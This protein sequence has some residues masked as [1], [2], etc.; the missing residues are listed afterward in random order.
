[1]IG[2]TKLC[3]EGIEI[4][5]FDLDD[6]ILTDGVNVSPRVLDAITLARERGCMACVSSGRSPHMVPQILR[7][8]QAMDYLVC[9]NGS[10]VCDNIGGTMRELLIP[11]EHALAA[12]D[13]LEPLG[14][15]WNAFIGDQSYFEWRSVSYMMVGRGSTMDAGQVRK[16]LHTGRL[17]RNVHRGLRFTKRLFTKREGFSQVRRVRPFLEASDLDVTKLGCSL[18]SL[19]ACDRAIAILEHMGGFE[20]ARMRATE[21][22]ITAAGATKGKAAGWLM[23]HL[24]IDPARAVAFG[25]SEND[26]TLASA[27]GTFVVMDNGDKAVKQLADDVCESVYDDGVARWIERALA[28]AD[29]VRNV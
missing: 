8:P 13:A 5:F 14:P 26:A 25:D 18:Q 20:V 27:C 23:E 15:G 4:M 12:M 19:D 10:V 22:E 2:P 11:R 24:G 17:Y 6:T 16:S 28:E 3:P 9:A 21:L 29:G 1:M 7:E